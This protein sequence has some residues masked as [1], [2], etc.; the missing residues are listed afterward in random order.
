MIYGK[1]FK[2][3]LNGIET[4]LDH[5]AGVTNPKRKPGAGSGGSAGFSSPLG[6][7]TGQVFYVSINTRPLARAA[8]GNAHTGAA[9]YPLGTA[10]PGNKKSPTLT[11][12]PSVGLNSSREKN[13]GATNVN[14]R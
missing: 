12:I 11:P 3:A 14:T 8:R 6:P 2:K 5:E 13:P 1:V 9:I 7:E 10:G 4:T